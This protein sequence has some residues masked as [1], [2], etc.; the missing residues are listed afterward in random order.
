M[1]EFADDF[2][3]GQQ[4]CINGKPHKQGESDAYDR[5]FATQYAM[6]Q[7]LTEATKNDR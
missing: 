4:D 1:N 5:G 6:E 3:R 7:Q 2:L